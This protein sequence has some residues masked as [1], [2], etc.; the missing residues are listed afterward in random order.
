MS[1]NVI[2]SNKGKPFLL[3]GQ[4][5]MYR[6]NLISCQEEVRDGDIVKIFSEDGQYVASGFYSEVSHIAVRIITHDEKE[7]FDDQFWMRRLDKALKYRL[8]VMK[9]Q[10]DNCRIIYGEADGLPGWT[11]DR[12]NDVLVSQI[13][14]S[15]TERRRDML[16]E[17]LRQV[18][19]NNGI[20]ISNIYERNDIKVREK[21]GLPLYKG[22]YGNHEFPTTTIIR[23]NGILIGVDF[24]NGQ[25]TGYFLDQKFNRLY[26]QKM[27]AGLRVLDCFSHTGGFALNAARGHAAAVTAVDVSETALDQG[28]QNALM[29][30]LQDRIEFIQDDVF[31]Y[32]DKCLM[33]QF[34]LII[35]DPPAFTKSRRTIEHAYNGYLEINRKAMRILSNGSY[36][37]SCSCSRFMERENFE[38]M[39]KQ[40]AQL[41]GVSLRIVESRSQSPDHPV[42]DSNG[43]TDYLKFYVLQIIR[44]EKADD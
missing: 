7:S 27:A 13:S 30:G 14:C 39:L 16:F 2:V 18:F 31:N 15:G 3:A 26:L 43:E 24:A 29:N 8:E 20:D 11:V 17:M 37:I 5:W 41:E 6:N 12:Y 35:L 1:V 32:L 19:R 21:E 36:L 28:Y 9:E 33:N 22:P 25:K 4:L 42:L 40:A 34:D 10:C 38:R 23:E 44:K